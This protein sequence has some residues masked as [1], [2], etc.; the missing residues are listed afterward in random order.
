M[1]LLR[2]LKLLFVYNCDLATGVEN[3]RND[4]FLKEKPRLWKHATE[5]TSTERVKTYPLLRD[6]VKLYLLTKNVSFVI[7]LFVEKF[8]WSHFCKSICL[9]IYHLKRHFWVSI[10]SRGSTSVHF[11]IFHSIVCINGWISL[12]CETDTELVSCVGWTTSDEL[13]SSG[14]VHCYDIYSRKQIFW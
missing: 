3:W 14:Y 10:W 4:F 2:I 13:Y 8:S 6:Q 11:Y 5:N 1:F 9:Q 7:I 12:T